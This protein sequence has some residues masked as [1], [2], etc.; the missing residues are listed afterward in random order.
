MLEPAPP[1]GPP[2]VGT[3]RELPAFI[4]EEVS[5][6]EKVR[7]FLLEH[8]PEPL[9]SDASVVREMD[10]LL[11]EATETRRPE[12]ISAIVQQWGH[13]E[14]LARQIRA[15]R[16]QEDIDPDCPYFAHLRIEDDRGVRDVLIGRANRLDCSP[17]IVDWR[18]SPIA[19][20]YYR[21][22]E[23]DEYEEQIGEINLCGRILARRS[24][25]ISRG[26]IDRID[27]P[28]GTWLSSGNGWRPLARRRPSLEGKASWRVNAPGGA[29]APHLGTQQVYRRQKHLADITGLL[30][31][32]QYALVSDVDSGVLAVR[33]GAGSGKTTVALHRVA[34]LSSQQPERFRP[35]RMLVVVWGKALRNYVAHVL[36]SL[37][38]KGIP[39]VTWEEWAHEKRVRHFSRL[40]RR[41][42][43]QTPAALSQ[44]KQH[45]ELMAIL[46]DQVALRPAPATIAEALD[47]FAS[48]L[49]NADRVV[50]QLAVRTAGSIPPHVLVQARRHFAEQAAALR[51]WLEGD[52]ESTQV[53]DAEDEAILLYLYQL[54]VGPLRATRRTPL[55]LAHLVVDEVQDFAAIEVAV[56]LGCLDEARSA[57]LAGDTAQQV[58]AYG[59]F[60]SWKGFLEQL[61]L[62]GAELRTLQVSYRST[63]EIIDFARRVLGTPAD[64]EAPP[65]TLRSGPPV[66]LLRFPSHGSCVGYLAEALHALS[67]DEPLASVAAIAATPDLAALYHEGLARAEVPR[68]RRVVDQDFT[69]EPGV[70]VAELADVKGLEFDYVILLEASAHCFPDTDLARRQL[71]VAIT[72]AVHQVWITVVDTPAVA[73]RPFLEA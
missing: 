15:G 4:A 1:R 47:D 8:P 60:T 23:G 27:G 58:A 63:N 45:P 73:V 32:E 72:R 52:A 17:R 50:E 18:Q 68:L 19:T 20:L 35:E 7:R 51:A 61:G 28:E 54:R 6:L 65:G 31:P 38:V 71:H 49:G 57:T 66:E 11:R 56:L 36:P 34:W 30:D 5:I 40:P 37:G 10:G 41:C 70:E 59:G 55:S 69:F 9:A 12:D 39:I 29:S 22:Q 48:F 13:I 42:R 26:R 44:V 67:R 2:P 53:V 43:E 21:Y 62:E 33:G 64:V 14:G 25:Q 16:A 24:L 3:A 46:A